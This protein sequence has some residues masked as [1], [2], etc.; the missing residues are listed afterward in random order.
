[1]MP[2]QLSRNDNEIN[3]TPKQYGVFSGRNKRH[4]VG[5]DKENYLQSCSKSKSYYVDD[6][7]SYSMSGTNTGLNHT[8]EPSKQF[9]S[10]GDRETDMTLQDA[11]G[12]DQNQM[13]FGQTISQIDSPKYNDGQLMNMTHG[14]FKKRHSKL[15]PQPILK[16]KKRYNLNADIDMPLQ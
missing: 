7:D 14:L 12:P 3:V 10:T 4:S 9:S 16:E 8:R 2:R 5:A 1:M 6:P 11:H 13:M 15:L